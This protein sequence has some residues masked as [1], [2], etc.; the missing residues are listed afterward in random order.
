[1]HKL[2]KSIPKRENFGR[3]TMNNGTPNLCLNTFILCNDW[4][5][6]S[7]LDENS[8]KFTMCY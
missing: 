4:I 2:T 3:F 1:M 8:T 7:L 6:E 5:F